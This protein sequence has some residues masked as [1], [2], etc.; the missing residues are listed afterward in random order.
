MVTT[1]ILSC[2]FA[3]L[4]TGPEMDLFAVAA[5]HKFLIYG[6]PIPNLCVSARRCTQFQLESMKVSL[7][8]SAMVSP[9]SVFK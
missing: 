9:F 5:S 8:V 6:S 3:Y 1:E 2:E 4:Y 7:P